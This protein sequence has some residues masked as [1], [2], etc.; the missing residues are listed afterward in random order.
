MEVEGMRPGVLLLRDGQTGLRAA[1][2]VAMIQGIFE[3]EAG[4]TLVT[5]PGGRILAVDDTFD[6]V[7]ALIGWSR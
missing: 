7:V 5:L 4:G 3:G 2:R 6:S 1:V